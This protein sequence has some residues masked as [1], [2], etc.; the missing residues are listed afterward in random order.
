LVLKG[1]LDAGSTPT[2]RPILER[3]I[4]AEPRRVLIDLSRLGLLD[5]TGLR[6]LRALSLI[7]RARGVRLEVAGAHGQPLAML[8]LLQLAVTP[9]PL[10]ESVEEARAS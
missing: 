7:C 3:V 9:A 8:Q 6:T 10:V 5:A 4:A 1:S 2:L